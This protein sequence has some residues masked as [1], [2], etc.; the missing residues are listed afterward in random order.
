[1]VD[2]E[3]ADQAAKLLASGMS[4]SA[5]AR[6]LGIPVSTFNE[7]RRAGVIT[8]R[9]REPAA[10]AE[11]AP[12]A[13]T[14]DHPV[15]TAAVSDPAVA[16][17]RASRDARDKHAPM[18]RAARDVERRTLARAGLLTEATPEFVEPAHAVAGGG[19]LAALPMLL[20]EGLL[21]AANRLFHLPAGFYGLTS[22]LLFV[23][24]M[25]L[26]RVRNPESLR[27]QAPGEWGAILGLD[28]CPETETLRRKIGLLASAEH[29]VRDWQ[30]A[31]A[32]TWASEHD[33]DWTTLAVDGHVKVYTGRNGR[34]PKHFVA[35]QKLCLPASVSYWINALGGAPLLCLHKALDPKLVKAIEH[36]VV[37]QL[38]HLGVV[39]EA[40][41]DLTGPQAG[42]PQ[43]TLVFDREGWSPDLFKRLARRGIACITWHKNFKGGLA[44]GTLPHLRGTD[45]RSRRHQHDCR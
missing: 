4:G 34:L 13:T 40:A 23:A 14:T 29:T 21:T 38:Q 39:T 17:D 44:A 2:A 8:D 25:T 1:M 32:R 36:D 11:V 5:C 37:P 22:I 20:R 24:C 6:Q 10:G 7:N 42:L 19:V 16:T 43:L 33:D 9:T 3:M 30:S 18:G 15:S 28:R 26:A 35:R 12:A 45:P 41:P 31:L 27:Y